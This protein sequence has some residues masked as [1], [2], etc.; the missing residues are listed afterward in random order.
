MN[1]IT[2]GFMAAPNTRSSVLVVF[3]IFAKNKKIQKLITN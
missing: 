3:D 2:L 1:S